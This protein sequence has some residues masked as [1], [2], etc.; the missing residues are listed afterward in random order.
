MADAPTTYSNEAA[1][2]NSWI[3]YI[4]GLQIPAAG[5]STAHGVWQIPEAQIDLAPDPSLQRLGAED[6]VMTQIF[7]CDQWYRSSPE[8][9]LMFDGEIVA[10]GTTTHGSMRAL[11]FTCVDYM[12]I[13]TQLFFFFMSS[14]D[15]IAIGVSGQSIG[16]QG[17]T[18]QM[19][20]YGALYPYSLFTQGLA[21][22]GD[23]TANNSV[24]SRP[25]DFAYNI[26]RALIKAQHPNRTIPAANF[27]TPWCKRTNFHRRWIALPYLDADPGGNPNV[28]VFPILRAVQSEQA[29][30]AVVRL[31][32][33]VGTS[34]SMWD[35]LR[36]VLMTMMMEIAM[37]PTP[38]AVQSDFVSMLPK[39][40]PDTA[41]PIFLTNYF[42]KPQCFFGLPPSF[43]VFF[44]GSLNSYAYNENYITQPT[45]MYFNE[46]AI[47]SALNANSSGT[48]Q[49][50]GLTGLMQ[51]ALTTAYPEEVD[52]A[53]QTAREAP[54]F[55]GKN[56]LV[57]PE[58][59]FKGP[60]IDRRSMPRWFIYLLEASRTAG[61][62]DENLTPT[63]GAEEPA[64]GEAID[65]A[66][67]NVGAITVRPITDQDELNGA[68]DAIY[69][70]QPRG[71]FE[72]AFRGLQLPRYGVVISGSL[73]E[74]LRSNRTQGPVGTCMAPQVFPVQ[75][76]TACRAFGNGAGSFFASRLTPQRNRIHAG[77]DFAAPRGTLV[78]S[79]TPGT[80]TRIHP[81]S[82][83]PTDYAG[84]YVVVVDDQRGV[85][86][87]MHLDG[88]HPSIR[89]GQRINAGDPIGFVGNSAL[90]ENRNESRPE[91]TAGAPRRGPMPIHLHYDVTSSGHYR[92]N[93]TEL[94][95]QLK[96]GR[97][98]PTPSTVQQPAP[99]PP[100]PTAPAAQDGQVQNPQ[101]AEIASG[102]TIRNLFKTYAA[103]EYFKERYSRRQGAVSMAFNP[104]PVAGFPCITF[105][106]RSTR[107]D[108]IGY[109]M[110]VRQ[111]MTPRAWS[112]DVA[113]SHGRT[114][115]EM[116]ALM[117]RT[118]AT[119]AARLGLQRAQISDA[120][121]NNQR[122]TLAGFAMP[123]GA[124]AVA[125]AEPIG[126]IRDVIQ[127]F[128]RA[129]EFY[130]AI[131]YQGQAPGADTLSAQQ[132]QADNLRADDIA[133]PYQSADELAAAVARGESTEQITQRALTAATN[134]T[135]AQA[136]TAT[137]AATRP[138]RRGVFYYPD[139]IDL[140]TPE[141]TRS[142]I[143][144]EGVDSLTRARI[145]RVIGDIRQGTA[146]GPD[147]QFFQ[148]ATEIPVTQPEPGNDVPEALAEQLNGI[149]ADMR[150][151]TAASNV[152]G[153]V[154][155]VP[156][157]GAEGL[158]TSN[159]AALQFTGRPICTLDEYIDFLG[160]DGLR[161]GPVRPE[162]SAAVRG[163]QIHPAT[164]YTRIRRLRSGPPSVRPLLNITGTGVVTD[165]ATGASA[166][167]GTSSTQEPVVAQSFGEYLASLSPDLEPAFGQVLVELAQIGAVDSITATT[168]PELESQLAQAQANQQLSPAAVNR[169]R[170]ALARARQENGGTLPPARIGDTRPTGIPTVA[171]NTPE[172]QAGTIPVDGVPL[173]FPETRADWDGVLE[174]YRFNTLTRLAPNT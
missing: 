136:T 16:V 13:L 151:R 173:S 169:V 27:F 110:S 44:P 79:T 70:T 93:Y 94:L 171:S 23:S 55:N 56:L 153:D 28:G 140:V 83:S 72:R 33:D 158:F 121:F 52:L 146:T 84:N 105:D 76:P 87:Y 86:R 21:D 20:G 51:D 15:D 166:P 133:V 82:R 165:P 22:A 99:T 120:I 142:G 40:P 35:L 19:A 131:F 149:E 108:T 119:E 143:Q 130:K 103:Y 78:V 157:R 18:V 141:G 39:G 57:Y 14:F 92:L 144:I 4:N 58:E 9:C 48:P 124:I 129:D 137:S 68:T 64:E 127:N 25:V 26:V 49:G 65:G 100:Q 37:V 8:F 170:D 123:L 63:P 42:V 161:E 147:L 138:E 106:R 128:G 73:R 91:R 111:Q 162:Q 10:W 109:V 163:P 96:Q 160:P 112:T 168:I 139:V 85:H 148:E 172:A 7:Y 89:Q 90:G 71:S 12:Q 154:E 54:N 67:N 115:Q 101:T 50:P 59:F 43:N 98:A 61:R 41:A 152:R 114:L 135:T 53:A 104:Y 77:L 45:R 117:Q 47:L 1:A 11:T 3:V 31:A 102:D 145:I 118:Y 75:P 69:D 2:V 122:D 167:G 6:R 32:Q 113:F 156:R 150:S 95:A 116:F 88:F 60:V 134:A 29:I 62:P 5:V 24:I 81:A 159:H 38:C 126:E 97:A 34:G 17:S 46:E 66:V 107:T 174:R 155:I 132:Q 36:Q 74:Q 30:A 80:V 125:P 164:F